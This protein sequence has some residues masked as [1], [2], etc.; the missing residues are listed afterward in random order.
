M[1]YNMHEIDD[2]IKK[3]RKEGGG[4]LVLPLA[5]VLDPLH[6]K[7]VIIGVLGDN[8]AT[9][10]AVEAVVRQNPNIVKVDKFKAE[11]TVGQHVLGRN[12]LKCNLEAAGLN[13]DAIFLAN[14]AL[15]I[16]ETGIISSL[17]CSGLPVGVRF[18]I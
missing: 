4:S 10:D 17:R 14:L 15:L 6:C 8:D 12:T 18:S 7:T 2:L 11:R 1:L 5:E 16:N 9:A 3:H 13:K